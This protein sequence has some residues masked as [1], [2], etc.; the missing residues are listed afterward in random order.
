[1]TPTGSPPFAATAASIMASQRGSN[2]FRVRVSP[3]F[4]GRRR[5]KQGRECWASFPAETRASHED[6]VSVLARVRWVL[7]SL[8]KSLVSSA[9]AVNECDT[10]CKV[11]LSSP[12][13]IAAARAALPANKSSRSSKRTSVARPAISRATAVTTRSAQEGCIR[14][15]N[16]VAASCADASGVTFSVWG[17][18]A[19]AAAAAKAGLASGRSFPGSAART[20]ANWTFLYPNLLFVSE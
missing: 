11:L 14:D 9:S 10:L 1:M 20:C 6:D 2:R 3:A 17:T 7:A 16:A 8:A 12:E 18:A 13:I 5:V 19:A 15:P 4:K